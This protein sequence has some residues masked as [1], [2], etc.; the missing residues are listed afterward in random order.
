MSTSM[1]DSAWP[2]MQPFHEHPIERPG[3]AKRDGRRSRE[4]AW[5]RR[6]Q[7]GLAAATELDFKTPGAIV[8]ARQ[9]HLSGMNQRKVLPS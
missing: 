5:A 6:A 9:Q 4:L 2:E 7:P 8:Q 1:R 3:F